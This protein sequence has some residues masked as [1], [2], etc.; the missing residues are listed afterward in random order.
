MWLVAAGLAGM[1]AGCAPKP[2]PVAQVDE[3]SKQIN[4]KLPK[5]RMTAPQPAKAG[6]HDDF[7]DLPVYPGSTPLEN[8]EMTQKMDDAV[9]HAHSYVTTDTP[10]QVAEFY[11]IEGAKLGKLLDM[12]KSNDQL[13]IVVI[14]RTDGRKSQV[15]AMRSPRENTTSIGLTTM[16]K[17][18]P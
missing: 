15:M 7:V 3:P 11:R 4:L 9:S 10:A 8:T 5:T 18:K 14:A 17:L 16:S 13:K 6:T 12:P 2:E 1:L